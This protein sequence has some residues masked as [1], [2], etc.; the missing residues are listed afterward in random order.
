MPAT[1]RRKSLCRFS[2]PA[3]M[4]TFVCA[5]LVAERCHYSPLPGR[6][7]VLPGVTQSLS[8]WG[9]NGP[10][11][12]YPRTHHFCAVTNKVRH[13][14]EVDIIFRLFNLLFLL[15]CLF[16]FAQKLLHS[17]GISGGARRAVYFWVTMGQG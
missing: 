9:Y 14:S 2:R 6:S 10:T 4:N 7:K 17:A 16:L 5:G 11:I 12:R 13:N 8:L 1:L 15:L 3:G